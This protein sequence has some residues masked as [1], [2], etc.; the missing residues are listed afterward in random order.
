MS[1]KHLSIIVLPFDFINSKENNPFDLDRKFQ[2]KDNTSQINEFKEELL[3]LSGVG[4]IID[5][6]YHPHIT[7]NLISSG[8]N[9]IDSSFLNFYKIN[10]DVLREKKT[11]KIANKWSADYTKYSYVILNEY[12]QLGYFVF[13]IEME[14]DPEVSIKDLSE[15]VFFRFYRNEENTSKNKYAMLRQVSGQS[16][17]ETKVEDKLT[18]EDVIN[19]RFNTLLPFIKFRYDR[20]MLLHLL[21]NRESI[22]ISDLNCYLYNSIRMPKNPLSPLPETK[23]TYTNDMDYIRH[24]GSGV[25]I[26]VLNEGAAII[27]EVPDDLNGLFN[28]YFPA[29]ILALNQRE[30]MLQINQYSSQLKSIDFKNSD[31][32]ILEFLRDLKSRIDIYQFKQVFYSV[33]F[34]DEIVLFYNKLQN[35]FNI[36]ILLKDNKECLSSIFTLLEENR[37]QE[38]EKQR[39]DASIAQ[40]KRDFW[41]NTSLMG[42][43]CLGLFSFFKDLIPFSLDDQPNAYFGQFSIYYKLF[44]SISPFLVFWVLLRIMRKNKNK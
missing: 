12:A 19:S 40:E 39:K 14:A 20:P 13:G 27:D 36:D 37:L 7:N 26:C 18:F 23:G 38:E 44:S 28:K 16:V 10:A 17:S 3:K 5:K 34:F 29:F 11:L 6:K 43:G 32:E 31:P 9:N 25:S 42:I 15:L 4:K 8:L 22:N 2:L 30:I 24:T 35:A 1:L 33:S 21:K 41:I